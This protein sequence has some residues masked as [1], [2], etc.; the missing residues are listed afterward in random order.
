MGDLLIDVNVVVDI[1]ARREP[2]C[3][4]AAEAVAR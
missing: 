4:P 3:Q 1:C 2:F